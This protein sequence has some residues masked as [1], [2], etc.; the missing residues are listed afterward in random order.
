MGQKLAAGP[1]DGLGDGL[2]LTAEIR[3]VDGRHIDLNPGQRAGPHHRGT[4]AV[5][6]SGFREE[7]VR[8]TD[9]MSRAVEGPDHGAPAYQGDLVAAVGMKG[10]ARAGVP[11]DRPSCREDGRM[12]TLFTYKAFETTAH[13][14]P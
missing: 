12:E 2:E 14:V 11:L 6:L 9:G 10:Q 5:K 7:D 1:P 8:R 13:S 3:V 4:T